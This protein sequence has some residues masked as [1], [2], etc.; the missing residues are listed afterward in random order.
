[1]CLYL[2]NARLGGAALNAALRAGRPVPGDG[3]LPCLVS[4]LRR[5]PTVRRPVV[6]HGRLDL[7]AQRHYPV[8]ALL[9]EHGFL[10][11]SVTL[12][13]LTA[14]ANVDFLIWPRLARGTSVLGL[15]G[16]VEEAVFAA[17]ARFKV[18]AVRTAAG[19][20][21]DSGEPAAPD[22]AV[23]L[24]ELLPY[25]DY[26]GSEL[27]SADSDVLARLDRVLARR[28]GSPVRLLDDPETVARVAGS[29]PGMPDVP[30]LR[31]GAADRGAR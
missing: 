12:D 29:L 22:S 26:A 1:M 28:R 17:G 24:R 15:G 20:R 3:F 13:V 14:E 30:A 27:D 4:G 5:L 2:R 6:R 21:D 19:E 25:E 10:S 31:P 23:L 7:P 11:A 16:P 8:G 9:T 18:L